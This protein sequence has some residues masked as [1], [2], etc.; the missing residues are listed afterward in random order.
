MAVFFSTRDGN[1]LLLFSEC[2]CFGHRGQKFSLNFFTHNFPQNVK[3]FFWT[4]F[5][6]HYKTLLWK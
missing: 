3:Q 1:K 2:F 5:F 6:Q 4:K